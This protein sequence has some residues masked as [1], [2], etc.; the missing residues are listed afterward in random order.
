[1]YLF[2]GGYMLDI[3]KFFFD[4]VGHFMMLVFLLCVVT[5]SVVVIIESSKE[6]RK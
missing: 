4:D 1:M 2:L 5:F 3:F 6:N